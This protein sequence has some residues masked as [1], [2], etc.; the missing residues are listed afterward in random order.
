MLYNNDEE[1]R[2]TNLELIP[3]RRLNVKKVAIFITSVMT[4]FIIFSW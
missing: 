1:T 3:Q 2:L 4:C